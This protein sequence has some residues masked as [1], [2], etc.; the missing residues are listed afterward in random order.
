MRSS[1]AL[2][3]PATRPRQALASA[4]ARAAFG[5]VALSAVLLTSGLPSTALAQTGFEIRTAT[6]AGY[7]RLVIDHPRAVPFTAQVID[8][9][10]VVQFQ[11]PLPPGQLAGPAIQ[12]LEGYVGAA[13]V[14]A[15]RRQVSFVLNRPVRVRSFTN[16]TA[17]VIDLQ[18]QPSWPADTAAAA[19][20]AAPA[21]AAPPPPA[22]AAPS[23]AAAAA[24]P[25]ARIGVRVGRHDGYSRLAF[26]WPTGTEVT[27]RV[28]AGVATLTF[29]QPGQIDLAS[30][31]GRLPPTVGAIEQVSTAP[32]TLALAVP[33]GTQ[34]RSFRTGSATVVDLQAPAGTPIN[35]R[36]IAAVAA[37]AGT[38][39][40]LAAA[41]PPAVPIPLPPQAATPPTPVPQAQASAPAASQPQPAVVPPP[42]GP[43]LVGTAVAQTLSGEPSAVSV[44]LATVDGQPQLRFTWRQGQPSPA[45]AFLRGDMLYVVFDQPLALDMSGLRGRP[46]PPRVGPL[47]ALAVERGTAV[48]L[49]VPPTVNPMPL[50]AQDGWAFTLR[51]GPRRPTIAANLEVDAATPRVVADLRPGAV[52]ALPV[53]DIE[54]GAPLLV[55]PAAEA[56]A[57][58]AQARSFPQFQVLATLQGVVVKPLADGIEVLPVQNRVQVVTGT[59]MLISRENARSV[60]GLFD[61]R[62]WTEADVEFSEARQSLTQAAAEAPPR[63]RQAARFELAQFLIA[64]G[65]AA[66]A[67]GVL[68]LIV[69]DVPELDSDPSLKALRGIA[70]VLMGDG[71]AAVADLSDPRLDG[72]RDA[73]T[74][75]AAAFATDG[76]WPEADRWFRQAGEPSADL[77]PAMRQ[78]LLLLAAEAAL[79]VNDAPR[80]RMVLDRLVGLSPTQ[81]ARAESI[82]ARMLMQSGERDRGLAVMERLARSADPWV[83]A[84][85][86][87]RVV[88]ERV[89]DGSLTRREGAARLDRLRFA[90]T[91]DALQYQILVR[92]GEMLI[93]DGQHREGFGRLRDAIRFFPERPE[94]PAL[95]QKMVESF[96]GLYEGGPDA[97][98]PLAALALFDDF[99]DL[100]PAGPRGDRMVQNLADR[101]VEIDLLD[102]AAVLLDHQIKHRLQGQEKA[103]IGARLALVHLIDRRPL[104]ALAALD[105]SAVAGL[106]AELQ[107]ERRMIRARALADADQLDTALQELREDRSPGADQV[108]AELLSR[109]NQWQQAIEPLTRLAGDPADASMPPQRQA[110]VLNLAVATAMAGDNAAIRRLREQFGPRMRGSPHEAAFQLATAH[111][112]PSG[113]ITDQR[114]LDRRVADLQQFQSLVQTYR[115]QL[116]GTGSTN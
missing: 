85:N 86:E 69:Q 73:L 15:D 71:P 78:R 10:L 93:A 92:L 103:R 81:S 56:G 75:R 106:S 88:T 53:P 47:E 36:S 13:E 59:P 83:R 95:Q 89:A 29:S 50:R 111:S 105:Q 94:N 54:P 74:W 48:R 112:E 16:R 25:A 68:G 90:W 40:A 12:R 52:A 34:A 46:L 79:D 99:R 11:E 18:D 41:P 2:A 107:S 8:R 14:S 62:R 26:D 116:Q 3:S 23:S 19:P 39:A 35:P 31:R 28:E 24:V 21:V 38:G 45:A 66:D 20:T 110:A 80:V 51:P 57:G 33:E 96:V 61:F 1:Q 70:R 32:L 100:T 30:L 55:M 102:R 65:F 5:A 67:V 42:P 7:A 72:D 49:P 9:R 109:R 115:Q 91:G 87:L 104:D 113:R 64:R 97:P 4:L 82:R 84:V 58:V 108:R 63:E 98:A 76:R 114:S 60:A 77:P 6:H 17:A 37:L 27:A 22:V 44:G 43:S 101:L